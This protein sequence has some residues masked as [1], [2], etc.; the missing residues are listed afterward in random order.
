M[1]G[2]IPI[3]VSITVDDILYYFISMLCDLELFKSI[4]MIFM[5]DFI[6]L[7][8]KYLLGLCIPVHQYLLMHYKCVL[9]SIQI[10]KYM[11]VSVCVKLTSFV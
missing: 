6:I 5:F 4:H 2:I 7:Q 9:V 8:L 3:C 10:Y 11:H 1:A